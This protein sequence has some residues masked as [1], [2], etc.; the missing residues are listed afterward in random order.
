MIKWVSLFANVWIAEFYLKELWIDIIIANELLEKRCDLYNHFYP[1]SKIICWDIT[2]DEIYCEVLESALIQKCD[3]VLATPPC[4]WMSVAWKMKEDDER[5]NLIIKAVNFIKDLEPNYAIIENVPTFFDTNIFLNW[6]KIKIKDYLI[7]ELWE[8]YN[9]NMWILN[10]SDYF[11]PQI[12]K[13]AITLI[14]SKNIW[15]W[16]FPQKKENITVRQAI[17][18]LPS[19]ES[20]EYSNIKY[21]Y[22]K[23]HS[24]NHI[25]WMKNTPTGKTAFENEKYFPQKENWERIKWFSTTYK[26]IEW[27]KPAPTITMCNWAISSQNNVH[28]WRLL[29]NWIYSDARV[30]SLKEICILTGL[31]ENIDFPTWASDNFIR[32]VIWEWVPPKMIQELVKNMPKNNFTYDFKSNKSKLNLLKQESNSMKKQ[33]ILFINI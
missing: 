27:E 6:D 9:L 5:N 16:D 15:K 24:Q 2:K 23:K 30:L 28:P 32:Q 25:L 13:R 12:R 21:H 1:N 18:H 19:L 11:T 8:K 10:A 17:W 29:E 4:Q 31:P 26:R 33:E 22:A 14:S 3:F 20:W 7:Q